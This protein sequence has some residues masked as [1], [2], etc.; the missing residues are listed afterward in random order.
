MAENLIETLRGLSPADRD[1]EPAYLEDGDALVYFLEDVP[2][3]ADRVDGMLT[4][5]L[6]LDDD[7]LVGCRIKGVRRLLSEMGRFGVQIQDEGVTMNL[8]FMAPGFA[9]PEPTRR[10]YEEIG[11]RTRGVKLPRKLQPV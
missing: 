3:H 1:P 11:S 8:L 5:Y 6:S 2:H 7:R 9:K 4:A 10:R